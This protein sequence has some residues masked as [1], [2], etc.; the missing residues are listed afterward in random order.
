MNCSPFL[1]TQKASQS[2]YWRCGHDAFRSRILD[3]ASYYCDFLMYHTTHTAGG[4]TRSAK[5]RWVAGRMA[6]PMRF[7]DCAWAKKNSE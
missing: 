2:W 7:Y 6:M 5:Q 4:Y 1:T 3:P